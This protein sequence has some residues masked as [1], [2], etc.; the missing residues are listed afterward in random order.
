MKPLSI[1]IITWLFFS[2]A[3]AGEKPGNRE[4]LL[5][6]DQVQVIRLTYPPGSESGMHTHEFPNRVAYFVNGGKL[7]FI[8]GDKTRD[9]QVIE[10]KGGDAIF[11]PGTTHNVKNVGTTEVVIIETE[12][13]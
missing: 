10:I 7:E 1:L 9:K 13:K 5:D 2:I 12:I 4:V 3:C 11:V 6:N 8:P